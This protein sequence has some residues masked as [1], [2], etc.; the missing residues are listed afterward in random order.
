MTDEERRIDEMAD[1][2]ERLSTL[3]SMDVKLSRRITAL[4]EST[5]GHFNDDPISS[6]FSPSLLWMFAI[7]ALAPMLID[8]YKSWK[9][10]S[11]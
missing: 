9:M 1:F 8:A 5:R 4:E 11:S 6:M 2:H 3:E 10:Q 7:I